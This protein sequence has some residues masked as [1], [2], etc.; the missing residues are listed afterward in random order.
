MSKTSI[1]AETRSSPSPPRPYDN[2]HRCIYCG[3][4]FGQYDHLYTHTL[5]DHHVRLSTAHVCW[6]CDHVC[7]SEA[8]LWR[9]MAFAHY[10]LRKRTVVQPERTGGERGSWEEEPPTAKSRKVERDAQPPLIDLED[11]TSDLKQDGSKTE[12]EGLTVCPV[13]QVGLRREVGL[14]HINKHQLEVGEAIGRMRNFGA[15]LVVMKLV[16]EMQGLD[17]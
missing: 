12:V 3:R 15:K 6:R 7:K 13:C 9:H 2:K 17:G 1:M 14:E 11:C 4:K 10:K 16:W 8:G 5:K